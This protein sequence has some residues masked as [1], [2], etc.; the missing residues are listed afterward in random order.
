MGSKSASICWI[1]DSNI[2]SIKSF[3]LYYQP[4]P[5]NPED[6]PSRMVLASM[7]HAALCKEGFHCVRIR[8]FL[9]K[10]SLAVLR[11][12]TPK[13]TYVLVIFSTN[14]FARSLPCIS[15]LQTLETRNEYVRGSVQ[16]CVSVKQTSNIRML[17]LFTRA[18][19]VTILLL[20][21]VYIVISATVITV[22][23]S[24]LSKEACLFLSMYIWKGVPFL[25]KTV[26][27]AL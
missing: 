1:C 23:W 26:T 16:P 25:C 11:N 3:L 19:R 18:L 22:H 7:D 14:C 17:S 15:Y 2:N 27:K 9:P 10:R 20:M 5:T 12:L 4:V 8:K 13:T 6:I 24:D 21:L